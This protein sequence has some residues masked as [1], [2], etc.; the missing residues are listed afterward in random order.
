MG[1]NLSDEAFR[2]ARVG[3]GESGSSY[4]RGGGGYFLSKGV[5]SGVGSGSKEA[6]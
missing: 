4:F 1:V 5:G 3:F 2:E 6:C